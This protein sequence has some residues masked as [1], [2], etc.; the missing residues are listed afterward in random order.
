MVV[1][2]VSTIRSGNAA[3]SLETISVNLIRAPLFHTDTF[4]SPLSVIFPTTHCVAAFFVPSSTGTTTPFLI[5]SE[6]L[7]SSDLV[8]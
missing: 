4:L 5:S 7:K 3:K 8:H 6:L 1:A 2:F